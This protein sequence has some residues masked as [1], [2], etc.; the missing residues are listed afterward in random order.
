MESPDLLVMCASAFAAVFL[1]LAVLAFAMRLILV[2]FPARSTEADAAVLAA[3]HVA[4]STFYP[5][6]KATNIQEIKE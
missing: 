1:L 3:V 5:G 2:F 6:S 4:V